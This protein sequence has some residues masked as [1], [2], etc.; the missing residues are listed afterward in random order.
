MDSRFVEEERENC[1]GNLLRVQYKWR[2]GTPEP[3]EVV[4]QTRTA[5]G[6]SNVIREEPPPADADALLRRAI[7]RAK[8]IVESSV[9]WTYENEAAR[10]FTIDCFARTGRVPI[11][12]SADWADPAT[13]VIS[14]GDTVRA[15]L[16]SISGNITLRCRAA[17]AG[18]QGGEEEEDNGFYDV[19]S[20]IDYSD[21]TIVDDLCDCGC[22]K[23]D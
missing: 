14:D 21:T 23:E 9:R 15:V 8:A 22:D 1:A 12:E 5:R 10:P 2:D 20:D 6:T 18:A 13:T 17:A 4:G 19:E 16:A 7:N 11:V 3:A